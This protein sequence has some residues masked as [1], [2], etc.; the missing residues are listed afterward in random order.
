[1]WSYLKMSIFCGDLSLLHLCLSCLCSLPAHLD[2]CFLSLSLPYRLSPLVIPG[3]VVCPCGR[4]RGTV[5]E[6]AV[7]RLCGHCARLFSKPASKC[8]WTLTPAV[9]HAQNRC[10]KLNSACQTLFRTGLFT[11]REKNTPPHPICDQQPSFCLLVKKGRTT[12]RH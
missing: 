10:G 3:S 4:L 5:G 2:L 1:M 9:P 7:G 12:G 8:C 11:G 6:R